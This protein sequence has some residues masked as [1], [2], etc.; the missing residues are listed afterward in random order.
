MPLLRWRECCSRHRGASGRV[1]VRA[2]GGAWFE[3]GLNVSHIQG[4]EVDVE[5]A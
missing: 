5:D 4:Q 1:C 3:G 2:R